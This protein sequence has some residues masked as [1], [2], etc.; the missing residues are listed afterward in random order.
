MANS[1][2]LVHF[3]KQTHNLNKAHAASHVLKRVF[4]ECFKLDDEEITIVTD[5][6]KN[7]RVMAPILAGGYYLAAKSLG[8]KPRVLVQNQ[9]NKGENTEQHVET[10]LEESGFG[11]IIIMT[12]HSFGTTPRIGKSFRN[13]VRGR[14]HKFISCTGLGSMSSRLLPNF[15]NT[16]DVDYKSMIEKGEK[17][18][19]VFDGG[20]EIRV[21]TP[22]GSD[23]WVGI[24]GKSAISN[25]GNYS[26]RCAGG[27]IPAGEVYLPPRKKKVE[28]KIVIDGSSRNIEGTLLAREPITLTVEGGEVVEIAG[29]R[30]ARKLEKSIEWAR[31]KSKFPWGIR[32]VS[33]FGLGINPNARIV[34]AMIMDEKTLGTGHIAIG[35]NYWFG[36]TVYAI[37]HLDQ[38]FRNPVVEVDGKPVPKELYS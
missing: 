33:E 5:L 20:K 32:R 26:D 9:K 6:G 30:E 3:L 13:F 23:F 29:G 25:D 22:A 16:V 31:E 12:V 1:I 21:T 7:G 34:G 8:M 28:G 19:K 27:N 17:L 4:T 10:A 18:K 24:K 35:S 2:K 15:L 11:N 36:G 37:I 14:K 38:A